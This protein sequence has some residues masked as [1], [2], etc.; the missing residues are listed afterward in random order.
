MLRGGDGRSGAG[1]C[2]G[3]RAG[4]AGSA[5]WRRGGRCSAS[6]AARASTTTRTLDRAPSTAPAPRRPARAKR[7]SIQSRA[8][9]LGTPSDEGVVVEIQRQRALEPQA[10]GGLVDAAA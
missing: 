6:A 2:G 8:K 10:E 1:G 4:G 3:R 9:S 5:A 7:F